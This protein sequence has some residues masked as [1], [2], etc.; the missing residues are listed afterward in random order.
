[1]DNENKVTRWLIY[2]G[3]NS[4]DDEAHYKCP[5]CGKHYSSWGL[6]HKGIKEGDEFKCTDCNN[7]IRY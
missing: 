1:M 4:H 3:F 6:F 5:Y 2:I 7:I